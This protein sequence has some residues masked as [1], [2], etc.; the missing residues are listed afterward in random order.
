MV[1]DGIG[2]L[3]GEP[4]LDGQKRRRR[5]LLHRQKADNPHLPAL[6]RQRLG[7]FH[8]AFVRAMRDVTRPVGAEHD[9]ICGLEQRAVTQ[10]LQGRTARLLI[11]G[12]RQFALVHEE[13]RRLHA[14]LVEHQPPKLDA[15]KQ[16]TVHHQGA[17][18][19]LGDGIP[20]DQYLPRRRIVG[21]VVS[22]HRQELP[23]TSVAVSHQ[24]F[25][26]AELAS[27]RGIHAAQPHL[28]DAVAHAMPD[29]PQP[30]E[31][32]HAHGRQRK[33]NTSADEVS[34]AKR[35]L[36]VTPAQ[37]AQEHGGDTQ[38][39]RKACRKLSEQRMLGEGEQRLMPEIHAVADE[40][41]PHER[42]TPEHA[43]HTRAIGRTQQHQGGA[44]G[45]QECIEA[46]ERSLGIELEYGTKDHCKP[47][48]AQALA[49]ELTGPPMTC[50]SLPAFRDE[51]SHRAH[52][53][54]PTPGRKQVER[55]GRVVTDLPN[56]RHQAG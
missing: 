10:P 35:L 41:E 11:D 21:K 24:R 16:A 23:H 3:H 14:G 26:G 43:S 15:R 9:H 2:L 33:H 8:P 17:V 46:R 1:G 39:D 40:T 45:G 50:R 55:R 47:D 25:P 6:R 38:H 37:V 12:R 18:Q 49:N 52:E 36:D 27:Q 56:R 5:S 4:V 30:H 20:Q 42:R 51:R 32:R 44:H 31:R 13:R 53:Q 54:L 29:E 28:R 19:I 7:Q 34:V 22:C 48:T